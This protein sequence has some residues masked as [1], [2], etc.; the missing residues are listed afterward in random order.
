MPISSTFPPLSSPSSLAAWN[1]Y[2]CVL[3]NM[4]PVFHHP[5]PILGI[6]AA[7]HLHQLTGQCPTLHMAI[8]DIASLLFNATHS[9]N[10]LVDAPLFTD[11]VTSLL[12]NAACSIYITMSFVSISSTIGPTQAL[13]TQ[14][15]VYLIFNRALHIRQYII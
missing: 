15:L 3:N 14:M 12:F 4:D 6:N 1:A 7:R 13:G 9:I 2:S 5:I 8:D 10:L 11:D